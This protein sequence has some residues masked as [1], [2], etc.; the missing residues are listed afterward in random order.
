M[1]RWIFLLISVLSVL[2]SSAHTM[3][4]VF[5]EMPDSILPYIIK[6]RRLD[7]IDFIENNMKAEVENELS[8]KS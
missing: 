3:K 6:N 5:S 7:C 2:P 1:K 8:G 4:E